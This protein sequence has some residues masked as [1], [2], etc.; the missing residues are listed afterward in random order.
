MARRAADL[1]PPTGRLLDIGGQQV[2][3]HEEGAG[4]VVILT[5]G[6]NGNTRDFTWDLVPRMVDRY[7]VI[8]FDRPGLGHSQPLETGGD[9][10][11]EQAA[12]LD[13]AAARLGVQR[14]V[15]VGHSYGASVAM[16]WALDHPERVGAVV[17]LAG[18]TMPWP[19]ELGPW[20]RIASN[21]VGAAI[22]VPLVAALLPRA[23]AHRSVGSVFAP[24]PAPD[25]YAEHI[26]IDLTLRSVSL[27][28]NARQVGGLKPHVTEMARRYPALDLPVELLHGTADTIVPI[29]VHARPLSKLLPDATLTELEGVG[30]MPHHVDPSATLAAID[31]AAG[32]AGLR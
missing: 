5:H 8:A 31:R 23:L 7:R 21:R 19:G 28:A 30:H 1:Y 10:P 18:A 15:V 14:A 11:A 26:G 29:Q 24:Q 25:G 6:A 4:P 13:A 9:S 3:V 20:Y 32:R 12:V 22:V 27:R 16:A 2:H 17:S